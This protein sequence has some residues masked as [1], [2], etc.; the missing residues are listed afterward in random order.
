M[1]YDIEKEIPPFVPTRTQMIA[2]ILGGVCFGII[3]FLI[4]HVLGG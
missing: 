4:I 3:A 2:Y 1:E